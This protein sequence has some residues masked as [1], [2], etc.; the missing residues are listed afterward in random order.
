MLFDIP[1]S[2]PCPSSK[3]CATIG[4]R[5]ENMKAHWQEASAT[6]NRMPFREAQ[7][8]YTNYANITKLT[9]VIS[10]MPMAKWLPNFAKILKRA[11]EN[12]I[13]QDA[14]VYTVE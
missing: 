14:A 12:I 13:P 5:L 4:G 1:T 9:S 6:R 2:S 11:K 10:E 8:D 3:P 7:P